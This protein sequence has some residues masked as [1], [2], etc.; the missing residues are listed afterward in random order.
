MSNSTGSPCLNNTRAIAYYIN[1]DITEVKTLQ[2][3][4]YQFF[5]PLLLFNMIIHI[6]V[7]FFLHYLITIFVI[8]FLITRFAHQTQHLEFVEPPRKTREP[9]EVQ[10]ITNRMTVVALNEL[11]Q[12]ANLVSLISIIFNN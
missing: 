12:V 7:M 6:F 1:P 3:K 9:I 2:R 8:S 5:F 4:C 10:K 11:D